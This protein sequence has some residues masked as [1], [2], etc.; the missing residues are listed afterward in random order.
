MNQYDKKLEEFFK[1]GLTLLKSKKDSFNLLDLIGQSSREMTHSAFI[2]GFLNPKANHG[3][4][5]AFLDIFLN[6]YKLSLD[7]ESASVTIEKDFGRETIDDNGNHIGGRID[8]FIKDDHDNII[9]IENKIFA[10]DQDYQLERYWNSTKRKAQII[11]L[12]LDGHTPSKKSYGNNLSLSS[13]KCLSYHDIK[14]WLIE[15]LNS[16]N[17]SEE[18]RFAI[19]QYIDNLD[20]LME[21][22][23]IDNYIGSSSENLIF[24]LKVAERAD[25]VR[26]AIRNKFMEYLHDELLTQPGISSFSPLK[27]EGREI[28]FTLEYK[29]IKIDICLDYNVYVRIYKSSKL[30]TRLSEEWKRYLR[31]SPFYAWKYLKI[32]SETINFHDFTYPASLWID[33]PV[34]FK[35]KLFLSLEKLLDEIHKNILK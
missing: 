19:Q 17:L 28:I 6:K 11:Y 16:I 13:F 32:N 20:N 35:K 4:R 7:S 5:T 9:V 30:D 1:N 2:A 12:T 26:S 21:N 29:G 27:N 25:K 24:S 8:I 15:G 22:Y 34:E 14:A 18:I 33:S 3:L 10:G 23:N 31:N